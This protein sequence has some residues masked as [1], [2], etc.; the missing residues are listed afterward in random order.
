MEEAN[1]EIYSVLGAWETNLILL[2]VLFILLLSAYLVAAYLAG[3]YL[4]RSQAFV[5]TGLML[6]FSFMIIV[7]IHS[8]MQFMIDMRE[9]AFFGYTT[10]RKA[11]IFKW[12][13]TV[14]CSLAPLA[15]IRFMVHTRHPRRADDINT[16]RGARRRAD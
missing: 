2:V 10:L 1:F 9:L 6:W 5:I 15:C 12:L 7:E 13:V 3:N 4:R 14:G 8:A 16:P 11:T